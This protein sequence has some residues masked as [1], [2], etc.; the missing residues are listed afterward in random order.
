MKAK[1]RIFLCMTLVMSVLCCTGV[2]GLI[3][4]P[5]KA[6][7]AQDEIERQLREAQELA[8]RMKLEKLAAADRNE[9]KQEDV[10]VEM[11]R[12]RYDSAADMY[13]TG[14]GDSVMLAAT[15]CLYAEF[16]KGY[17]DAVF[18]STIYECT[19]RLIALEEENGLGDVIVLSV[20]TNCNITAEDCENIIEHSDGRPTFW[21]TTY[22]V[23]NDSNEIMTAVA[24][25]HDDAF[26][27]DWESYA[28]PHPEW[29]MDD[30]L[31]PNAEGSQ[32]Y[33]DFIREEIEK[34]LQLSEDG[35]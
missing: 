28:M 2:Y 24:N 33:A 7:A 32:A 30:H 6:K 17:F 34:D 11:L 16:G 26:M 4:A 25:N 10:T 22:G 3:F 21:L 14:I 20:G 27:I 13:V 1:N 29:I 12:K 31:H 35:E 9:L 18:G 8:D 5:A 23:S 15:D 19:D